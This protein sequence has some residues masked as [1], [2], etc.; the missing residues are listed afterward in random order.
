[1]HIDRYPFPFPT[2]RQEVQGHDRKEKFVSFRSTLF[3]IRTSNL[4]AE[5]ER[6]YHFWQFEP[7]KFSRC[8]IYYSNSINLCERYQDTKYFG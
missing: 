5:A 1:M 7:E 4:G 2:H 6:S 3:F 8:S